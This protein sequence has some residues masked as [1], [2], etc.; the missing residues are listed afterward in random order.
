MTVESRCLSKAAAGIFGDFIAC[1]LGGLRVELS[2]ELK[3]FLWSIGLSSGR[4]RIETETSTDSYLER[5]SHSGGCTEAVL[6][7]LTGHGT[8]PSV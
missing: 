2:A 7:V 6:V 1:G 4:L 3:S 8:Q 5:L